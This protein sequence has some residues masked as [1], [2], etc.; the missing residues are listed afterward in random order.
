MSCVF[1][2]LCLCVLLDVRR[3]FLILWTSMGSLCII[4]WRNHYS[5]DVVLGVMMTVL[6]WNWYHGR[7]EVLE[8]GRRPANFF[9]QVVEF[10]EGDK[11]ADVSS[12]KDQYLLQ[13]WDAQE[14]EDIENA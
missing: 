2:C 5:I 4:M 14:D 3:I 9:D 12:R 7:A 8:L 10:V 11:G 1:V 6:V 13:R